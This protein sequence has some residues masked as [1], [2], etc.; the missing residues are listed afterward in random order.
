M[1]TYI[2]SHVQDLIMHLYS[3]IFYYLLFSLLQ[4]RTFIT[5]SSKPELTLKEHQT[6]A[7]W[8]DALSR[9]KITLSFTKAILDLF[10]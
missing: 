10:G 3:I 4:T 9:A 2:P 7:C 1:C 8:F 6:G 5:L